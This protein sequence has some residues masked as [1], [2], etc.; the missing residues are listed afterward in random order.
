M[1]GANLLVFLSRGEA[2]RW[3]T[4]SSPNVTPFGL[5][6]RGCWYPSSSVTAPRT[7]RLQYGTIAVPAPDWAI[8]AGL[9]DGRPALSLSGHFLA[10]WQAYARGILPIRRVPLGIERY[11]VGYL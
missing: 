10:M 4:G 2:S 8:R 11:R 7:V 5:G 9:A 3:V 1:S 6:R